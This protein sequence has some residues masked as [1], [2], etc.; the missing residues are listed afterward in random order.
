[1][2]FGSKVNTRAD[3]PK[4]ARICNNLRN[5]I[6]DSASFNVTNTGVGLYISSK[7]VTNSAII[8]KK[9]TLECT[10]KS[11][12]VVAVSAGRIKYGN[13]VINVSQTDVTLTGSTEYIF[14]KCD[15]NGS[16][17][18]LHDA[19]ENIST[20]TWLYLSLAKYTATAGVYSLAATY[21]PGGDYEFTFPT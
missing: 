17:V 15:R 11:A 2:H 1:M 7:P 14:I 20:S 10:W 12:N 21:H 8:N 4:V 9:L 6:F 16:A 19:I 5:I 13:K 18:V 3:F